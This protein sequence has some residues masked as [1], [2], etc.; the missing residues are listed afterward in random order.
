M[1][2][3]RSV[4]AA[5]IAMCM[6]F[7]LAACGGLPTSSEVQEG[8]SP[9]D[10]SGTQDFSFLPDLPQP[11]A[12]AEE[13]V[14]GFIRAGS[15]PGVLGR[16]ERARE[17]LSPEFAEVWQA[18]RGVTVDIPGDRVYSS[19]EEGD[20][21]VSLVAAATVDERG[22]Y[23]RA[24][25]GPTD[26]PFTLAQQ[27]DGEWRIT[28]ARDGIV[29]D[30]DIFPSVF[31]E[32]SVT[33]FDPLYE[34][35]VPD[36]RWF[37]TANAATR[38]ADALVNK[39]RSAWLADAVASAFPENV[40]MLASVPVSDGVAE[41]DLSSE[42]L[43]ADSLTLDRML[44]QLE[45]S[46]AST[47][48]TSVQ[49]TVASSSIAAESVTTL[50]TRIASAPL[51]LTEEA[52]GF[53]SAGAIEPISGL[54]NAVVD[55]APTAVQVSADRRYA[56]VVQADGHVARVGAATPTVVVDD[57]AGLVDPTIDPFGV[58]WSVPRN[59]PGDVRAS[60]LDGSSVDIADAWA[61]ATSIQAMAISRDGTRMAALVMSGGRSVVWVAG[62]VRSIESLPVRLTDPV[63]VGVVV[64]T[65]VNLTWLDDTTIAAVSGN[66]DASA[67]LEQV[68]GG[69]SVTTPAA[70]GMTS[71]AGGAS[72]STLRLHGDDN[73]VYAKRG[74]NWEQTATG[75]LVL[76]TQQ[77]MP[78]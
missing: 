15:G 60:N 41:I 65:A 44:T 35:L 68:I 45:S 58:V 52:F 24:E 36:V 32:Y 19:T 57:R 21:T 51:V 23:Q 25:A 9:D 27:D 18:D 53:L 34:Y 38:V 6:M 42:A 33:Y 71:L 37:P 2:R 55:A 40:T 30:R 50:N 75:V 26:L 63:A 73:A 28:S 16:W 3:L 13:I 22:A 17:F 1:M 14:E 48:V 77:G 47:G 12:S 78:Q 10:S 70:E 11:G 20:V 59:H 31:H 49:L 43:N 76:A 64:G 66:G 62:V 7:V 67:V 4:L 39:P 56:A 69:P 61:E 8:L 5:C 72:A 54:S 46:L 29:L 74:T